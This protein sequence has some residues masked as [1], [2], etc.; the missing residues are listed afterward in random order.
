MVA[1]NGLE[2]AAL[3]GPGLLAGPLHQL[4]VAGFGH[5]HQRVGI[6]SGDRFQ[7]AVQ[8]RPARLDL[9]RQSLALAQPAL[10][11][12]EIGFGQRVAHGRSGWVQIDVGHAR[13]HCLFFQQCLAFEP[14]LPELALAVVFAVGAARNGFVQGLHEPAEAAQPFSQLGYALRISGDGQGEML[15]QLR[16]IVV[17]EY[18]R[19]GR[20]PT[21]GNFFIA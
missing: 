9:G 11:G 16:I 17:F 13:Q 14:A 4:D 18:A 6:Q 19:K 5:A 10:D 20:Q 21:P 2:G 8:Q 3:V 15:G 12:G 1:C 7:G